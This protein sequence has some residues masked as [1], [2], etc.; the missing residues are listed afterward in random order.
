MTTDIKSV[1]STIRESIKKATKGLIERETLIDLIIL[2]AV[3]GEHVLVIGPPGTAK[4]AAVR[5]VAQAMGGSYFEY[6]LGRFTEPSELF[7][8]VDLKK[9]REGT[10]ETATEGMLPEAEIVFLDEVF[11]A[12]TAVLNTLLGLLNERTF[13]RGHTDIICPLK[14]CVAASN[15]IP[16]D[17]LLAAFADRFLLHSFVESVPDSRLEELLHGGW[18]IRN[19]LIETKNQMNNLDLLATAAKNASMEKAIGPLTD[20]IRLLRA[21][22]VLLS[23]R[24][25]VKSL[26][27]MSAASCLRGDND[28]DERDLWPLVFVI[29][30]LEGQEQARDIL[31]DVLNLSENIT[32]GAATELA[33]LGPKARA[34]Q[35]CEKA[36]LIIANTCDVVSESER[37]QLESIGR[38]I[39]AAFSPTALPESLL[40]LKSTIAKLLAV[41]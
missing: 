11:L 25:I 4:S 2:A 38:E 17:E 13:R 18:S 31:K 26:S 35:I 39:D 14:V 8:P 24:R 7:G 28:P 37:L 15:T 23:D 1:A 41:N 9:L 12:S 10:V 5:R 34:Q 29:P 20:A 6:L 16:D 33:S 32:L 3:A 36:S 27:L 21:E 40:D 22:G 30:T 19:D